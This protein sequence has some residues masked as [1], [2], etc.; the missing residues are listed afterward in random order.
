MEYKELDGQD[1][2][3]DTRS[4]CYHSSLPTLQYLYVIDIFYCIIPLTVH[5]IIYYETFDCNA[6][7]CNIVIVVIYYWWYLLPVCL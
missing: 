4:H 5:K 7:L 3:G 2:A 6:Y 1:S